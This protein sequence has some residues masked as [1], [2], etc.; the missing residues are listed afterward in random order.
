METLA[1]LAIRL[2]LILP[3]EV[4]V[5]G[6]L[7][8]LFAIV[9]IHVMVLVTGILVRNVR[10]AVVLLTMAAVHVQQVRNVQEEVV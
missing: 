4:L 8:V 10:E 3:V 2:V 6:V 1:P 5:L 9:L 7:T